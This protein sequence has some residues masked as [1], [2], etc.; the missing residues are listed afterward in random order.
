V[1]RLPASAARLAATHPL[2]GESPEARLHPNPVAAALTVGLTFPADQ[3]T[4]TAVRDATGRTL[5]ADAHETAGEQTLR[6]DVSS[7]KPGLYFLHLQSRQGRWVLKFV[8]Q[9][10]GH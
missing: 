6:V 4:A 5:I 8:K 10:P 3:V 7:L 1:L 9:A 2:A